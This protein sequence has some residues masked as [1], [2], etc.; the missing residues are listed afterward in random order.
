MGLKVNPE[1]NPACK[2]DVRF[3]IAA[4]AVPDQEIDVFNS[5]SRVTELEDR[6]LHFTSI[7]FH[8]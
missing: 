3:V 7:S 1:S 8:L 2:V 6:T 5:E 4:F